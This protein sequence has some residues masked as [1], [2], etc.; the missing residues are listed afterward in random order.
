[1]NKLAD[2]P[3]YDTPIDMLRHI[4]ESFNSCKESF[5]DDKTIPQ[6]MN[7][8]NCWMRSGWDFYPD[9]WSPKQVKEAMDGIVPDWDRKEQPVFHKD[10]SETRF[11]GAFE[12]IWKGER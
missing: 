11:I 1:M 5:M 7:I 6:L 12:I 10:R 2:K 8:Y 4:V 9:Q 3:L